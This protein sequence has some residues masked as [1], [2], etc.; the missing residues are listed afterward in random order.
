[1]KE[2][3]FSIGVVADAMSWVVV[4]VCLRVFLMLCQGVIAQHLLK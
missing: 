1:M 2:H 3:S 4:N